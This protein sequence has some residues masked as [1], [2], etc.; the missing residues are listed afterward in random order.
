MVSLVQGAPL[1]SHPVVI[2]EVMM[3][4]TKITGFI[5]IPF[6]ICFKY[7]L[8]LTLPTKLTTANARDNLLCTYLREVSNVIFIVLTFSFVAYLMEQK[9]VAYLYAFNYVH[10][11]AYIRLQRKTHKQQI[12]ILSIYLSKVQ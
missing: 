6:A 12:N 4:R 1:S 5:S 10:S 11:F 2:W 9:N 7:F 3:I 8:L